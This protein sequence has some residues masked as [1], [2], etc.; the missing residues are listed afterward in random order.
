MRK[1]YIVDIGLLVL[2][3]TIAA[4]LAEEPVH[5][6]KPSRTDIA[7]EVFARPDMVEQTEDSGDGSGLE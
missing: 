6:A 4:V 2:A 3:G 5:P 7:G 1:I